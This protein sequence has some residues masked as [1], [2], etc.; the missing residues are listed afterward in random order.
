[1]DK[2]V[3]G[4]SSGHGKNFMAMCRVVGCIPRAHYGDENVIK[5]VKPKGKYMLVVEGD[6]N[7]GE[8]REIVRYYYRKPSADF[9]QRW[10]RGRKSETYGKLR[11]LE[12]A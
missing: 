9:S 2:I 7:N 11:V 3:N 6:K 5:T 4:Y 12:V 8:E 10:L 1:L